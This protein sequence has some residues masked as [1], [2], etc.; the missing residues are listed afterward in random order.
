MRI[1]GVDCRG[2]DRDHEVHERAQGVDA[3]ALGHFFDA[4]RRL[5]IGF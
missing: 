1:T 2:R 3:Q 4:I 5:V